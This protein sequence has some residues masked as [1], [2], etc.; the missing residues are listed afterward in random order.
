GPI[1]DE[2]RVPASEQQTR[3]GS[4]IGPEQRARAWD[5]LGG[6][7]DAVVGGVGSGGTLTGLGR[8]FAKASPKTKM[9]LADPKGSVLADLV[10]TGKA[11][12]AGSWVIGGT[13]A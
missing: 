11:G 8:F 2:I 13:G 5:R 3:P 7:V 12:E 9:V 6:D 10:E 4:F 1:S